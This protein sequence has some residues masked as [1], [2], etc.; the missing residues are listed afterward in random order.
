MDYPSAEAFV[1]D[2]LRTRLPENLH[3]HGLDHTRD[4]INAAMRLADMEDV[5]GD[6]R[7]L[8][9]TAALFHDTGFTV[10]SKE[11]EREGCAIAK[12]QLPAFEYSNADIT[13]ITGIIMATRMP[14]QPA[15]HLQ[16]IM[17]DADLDYLGRDD[18]SAISRKLFDE[19]NAAGKKI[20]EDEWNRQEIDFL[21][22]HK[23]WT[24]SAA[25]LRDAGKQA[26]LQRARTRNS[27]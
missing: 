17:C 7:L 11:H 12:A 18:Y 3:Y 26:H 14:Q 22:N 13:V 19:W 21:L 2:L 16:K 6:D 8:L 1:F 23:Y 4:V 24:D 15:T 10:S 9:R 27:S 20:G 5:Q 25:R